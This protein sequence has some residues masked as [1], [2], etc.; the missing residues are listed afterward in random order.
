MDYMKELNS[1][2][3]WLETNLLST[4][5][6]VLWLAL[7]HINNKAGWA[8]EFTVAV[9]VLCVKT[10]LSPRAISNARNE[11][12][13]KGRIDWRSRKGNQS[14]TY[15]IIPLS[16]NNAR[17]T[18]D[19]T[20]D[21]A[22]DKCTDNTSTLK[23]S[24]KNN[25]SYYSCKTKREYKE[26]DLYYILANRL[27][28]KILT[29]NPEHKEPS[30]QKWADDVRL[31]MEKDNRNQAQVEYLI[32]WAQSNSFWKSNILSISKL[33]EKFD[34]LAIQAK[35]ANNERRKDNGRASPTKCSG[36]VDLNQFSL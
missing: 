26:D 1:F 9:S 16:A 4:S 18:S 31:M 35:E 13:Q 21:N 23:R 19:I 10:G 6:I 24:F 34:Q 22:S 2:Y 33:R 17:I 20:S 28:Q 12:K 5:G 14:A 29:N 7:M 8:K 25:N 3:D 11:L 15:K 32:D 30:L 36:G 27:Y